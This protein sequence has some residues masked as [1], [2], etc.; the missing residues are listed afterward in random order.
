MV[1]VP[2]VAGERGT[3]GKQPVVE[4]IPQAILHGIAGGLLHVRKRLPTAL[5]GAE[6]QRPV[7][8]ARFIVFA[9]P[10]VLALGP[11][12]PTLIFDQG[13]SVV[14]VQAL[15]SD[16]PRNIDIFGVDIQ[17]LVPDDRKRVVR[18]QA[19]GSFCRIAGVRVDRSFHHLLVVKLRFGGQWVRR[20]RG[21][22]LWSARISAP[23]LIAEDANAAEN[24]LRP[25]VGADAHAAGPADMEVCVDQLPLL[26]PD[27]LPEYLDRGR[28][29]GLELHS[30]TSSN[31]RLGVETPLVFSTV[32]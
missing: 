13:R 17:R 24:E 20:G 25:R 2:S 10:D 11:P 16:R 21:G 19:L 1:D 27:F 31:H 5:G 29:G 32:V 22:K 23:T 6:R 15:R 7:G 12:T 14:A 30:R 4:R 26:A 28:G 9:D 18:R 3:S 8:L